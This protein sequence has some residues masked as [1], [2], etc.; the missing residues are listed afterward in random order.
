[1]SFSLRKGTK[2]PR[3]CPVHLFGLVFTGFGTCRMAPG[4]SHPPGTSEGN[5]I[6]LISPDMVLHQSSSKVPPGFAVTL[7]F[8]KA[9]HHPKAN[10]KEIPSLIN[11]AHQ[12][13]GVDCTMPTQ[14]LQLNNLH[15]FRK[16]WKVQKNVQPTY[17]FSL[18]PTL[19]Y[20]FVKLNICM[21]YKHN[22][23]THCVCWF[24]CVVWFGLWKNFCKY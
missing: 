22:G 24:M 9:Y 13:Y 18:S 8:D 12:N 14:L 20:W 15:N 5:V 4:S 1:M 19:T 3:L 2:F 11:V 6:L 7:S 17:D 21:I 10:M 23:C 16:F